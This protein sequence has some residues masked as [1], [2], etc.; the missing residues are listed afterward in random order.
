MIKGMKERTMRQ[1]GKEAT[2][3]G[4]GVPA[5]RSYESESGCLTPSLGVKSSRP[6]IGG[7]VWRSWKG[8]CT[9]EAR[10]CCSSI[11]VCSGNMLRTAVMMTVNEERV[12]WQV[13]GN[14]IASERMGL[15][16]RVSRGGSWETV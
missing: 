13:E 12:S 9:A 10:R 16:W 1:H 6:H 2:S 15:E 11:H 3:R 5:A 7:G 4:K 14:D 8:L